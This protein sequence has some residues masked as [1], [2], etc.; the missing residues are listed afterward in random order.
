[1]PMDLG[2]RSV[3]QV[4]KIKKHLRGYV[5]FSWLDLSFADTISALR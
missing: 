1:M 3:E 5:I 2:E 4:G